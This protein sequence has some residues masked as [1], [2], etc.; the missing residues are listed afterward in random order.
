M[1]ASSSFD[2]DARTIHYTVSVSNTGASAIES[3]SF[4]NYDSVEDPGAGG[5]GPSLV[6]NAA[7]IPFPTSSTICPLISALP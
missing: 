1:S 7:T 3:L 5:M 2:V 4:I 6:E